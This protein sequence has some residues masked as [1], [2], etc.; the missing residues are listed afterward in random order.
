MVCPSPHNSVRSQ[1]RLGVFWHLLSLCN[2]LQCVA[3]MR[4]S[5]SSTETVQNLSKCAETP[6]FGDTAVRSYLY[7]TRPSKRQKN[8]LQWRKVQTKTLFAS[9]GI[10]TAGQTV[11]GCV[12]WL[13]KHSG[14]AKKFCSTSNFLQLLERKG[15]ARDS[16]L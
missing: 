12:T 8:C 9:D 15:T 16:C 3:L 4:C 5:W 2:Q 7:F 6:C 1:I 10:S 13:E 14:E 11:K